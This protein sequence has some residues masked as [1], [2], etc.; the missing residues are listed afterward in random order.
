MKTLLSKDTGDVSQPITLKNQLTVVAFGLMDDDEVIFEVV[1]LS[2]PIK[3]SCE[4]PPGQ[5][6]MPNV[7]QAFPLNCCEGGA[8]KLTPTNPFVILD[9]PQGFL[10]RASWNVLPTSGQIV[11]YEETNTPNLSN[12]L[13]GCIDQPL[14]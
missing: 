6:V 2:D 7:A 10:I 9:A 14:P 1:L 13:R 4:C 12:C 5:V 8:I 11:L 3:A